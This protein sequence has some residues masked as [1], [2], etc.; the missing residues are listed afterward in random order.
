MVQRSH[1]DGIYTERVH[2]DAEFWNGVLPELELFVH[3]QTPSSRDFLSQNQIP[4]S[5]S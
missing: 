5:K 4:S 3:M 1:S 2:F